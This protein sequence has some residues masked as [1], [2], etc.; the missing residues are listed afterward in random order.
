[1]ITT[2]EKIRVFSL[3]ERI[4]HWYAALTMCL[5]IITGFGMMYHSFH[6]VSVLFGGMTGI[7]IVHNYA[8]IALIPALLMLAFAWWGESRFDFSTDVEWF[9]KAGGYLWKVEDLPKTGK[10]NPGQ[11]TYFFVIVIFG[12]L[13]A[14][15][16]V[17]MWWLP[18]G[19][20]S[21][22]TGW[23]YT[24]HVFG[25]VVLVSFIVL[26]IYLGTIGVPGSIALVYSGMVPWRWCEHHCPKMMAQNGAA[27]ETGK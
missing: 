6:F 4:A 26:H 19:L 27:G 10:F 21:G 5:L 3:Y 18:E 17:L 24:L 23:L 25:V 20:G 12:T 22:L 16:G 14:A 1:M 2:E 11:K 9:K 7:K 13:M 15:T 8:G